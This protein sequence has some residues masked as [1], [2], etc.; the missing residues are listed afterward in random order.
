MV[1]EYFGAN[2]MKT[3]ALNVKLFVI[4]E[5]KGILAFIQ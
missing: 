1:L 3:V 5:K 2:H 4:I